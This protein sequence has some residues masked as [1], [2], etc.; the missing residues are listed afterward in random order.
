MPEVFR[1]AVASGDPTQSS[2]ILWTRV[3]GG[4]DDV[5]VQWV[6]ASDRDLIHVVARGEAVAAADADHTVHVDATGLDEATT[7]FYG[8]EVLG[9]HSP[10]GRT[11]TLPADPDH[12]RLAMVSCAK[13]AAGF[14]NGYARI[15]DRAD[16]DFV[17]HLGD[18]IYEVSNHPPPSQTPPADIGRPYMP[19]HE[20]VTLEDYRARYAHYRSDP[21]VQR[22]HV[23][24]PVMATVDDHEFADGA[25][26]EG[27]I[28]H[29]ED[30]DGPW[31]DRK[32]A[33]FRARWEWQPYRMLDAGDPTRVFRS[34]SLGDLA[35]L[36]FIDTRSR[37][38]GPGVGP[39][40]DDPAR[41]QLQPEQRSW[42]L[43]ALGSSRAR[44]RIVGNGSCMSQIWDEAIPQDARAGLVKL[45]MLNPTADG[46]DPDQWDGYPLERDA[47]YETMERGP[48]NVVVL[49]GDVH[50]SLANELKRSRD[51]DPV[52]V[53]FVTTSLTSQNLDD[54]MGWEPR[55][56]SVGLE[57]AW[58][59]A[60]PY[61]RWADLD[62]HGY[63]V[64]DVTPERVVGEW[65]FADTVLK[66][67]GAES[68]GGRWAVRHG[69][70]RLQ[71]G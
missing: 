15:A 33:A 56:R 9:E 31:A 64:V 26:R 35:D 32:A 13:Y 12:L 53:E 60:S 2:V 67:S 18:Y 66:Q 36:I 52:A 28:E 34:V 20:C 59:A 49:S 5:P 23:T 10:V 63:V 24:H 68:S 1:H 61:T 65:W 30:R 70:A 71:R 29:R 7:Y 57:A 48:R 16:L 38:D 3:T 27:S 37:R 55:T 41:T 8:F 17:V 50:V 22:L 46:P 40:M 6:V 39:R 21:D 19:E 42:F 47:I 69:T 58:V 51:A 62:S 11:R 25:W 54:K 14:F 44:W 43:D 4:P 45:K